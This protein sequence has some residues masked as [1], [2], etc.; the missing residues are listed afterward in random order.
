MKSNIPKSTEYSPEMRIF[1]RGG[2]RLYLNEIEGDRFLESAKE[3]SREY[4]VFCHTLYYTGCRP[5]EALELSAN[6]ID[7]IRHSIVIR[8]LKKRAYDNR[9]RK[10][11]PSF[12]SVAVPDRLI[13]DLALVF[14]LR[15]R[16]KDS[17]R[18]D[19]PLW[20][21]GR[22]TAWRVVKRVMA[23]AEIMGPQATSKGLRHAFGVKCVMSGMPL[24]KIAEWL[25]HT[26]SKTTEIY[27][28]VVDEE[29]R[30]MLM[31]VWK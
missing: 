15:A 10:K 27:T 21:I 22:Q 20:N 16:N 18:R 5:S 23:R 31:R 28:T 13:D 9:G 8:S 3:E 6:R 25:G 19:Q 17:S 14:D 24:H 26:D 7:L 29:D 1:D 2:N 4:H 30:E 12:R 11:Q